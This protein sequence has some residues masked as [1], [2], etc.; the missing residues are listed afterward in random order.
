MGE[1][2]R[3]LEID[4][5]EYGILINAL[6]QLRNKQ[7]KEERPTDPVDELLI[8]VIET[9]QKKSRFVKVLTRDNGC[10]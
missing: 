9:P 4:K 10:K 8:K 7:I 6:N 5:Y 2:K 1:E 3:I